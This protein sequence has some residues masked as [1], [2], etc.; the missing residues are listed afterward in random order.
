MTNFRTWFQAPTPPML[1]RATLPP[2][3]TPRRTATP[4]KNCAWCQPP[5]RTPHVSLFD[6][7]YPVLS[8]CQRSIYLMNRLIP[9]ATVS[10]STY[11]CTPAA[12][13]TDL[14]EC[15]NGTTAN[16]LTHV[17]QFLLNRHRIWAVFL[18]IEKD[19]QLQSELI[20]QNWIDIPPN[21][22]NEPSTGMLLHGQ[23]LQRHRQMHLLG[24]RHDQIRQQ[25]QERRREERCQRD[26]RLGFCHLPHRRRCLLAP[27][28][29]FRSEIDGSWRSAWKWKAT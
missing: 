16:T 19:L 7:S 26:Y 28:M 5:I 23:K 8:V 18:K 6:C 2:A 27:V 1:V 10:S 12:D 11:K 25:G 9:V 17:S 21:L 14:I 4:A 13:Q 15:K 29:T 20:C 22:T 3:T 24:R